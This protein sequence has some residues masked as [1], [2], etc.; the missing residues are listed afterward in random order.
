MTV[1][2]P[3]IK[4]MKVYVD[5]RIVGGDEAVI[6]VFD[7][8][9]LY[10][11]GVFEGIRVYGGRIFRCDAHIKRLYE[12]AASI[13]L[14]IPLSPAEMVEAMCA[15]VRATSLQDAYVRL[16]VTRGVGDLGLD[17]HKCPKPSVIVIVGKIALYPEEFYRQGLALVTAS[18][19][20]CA[21]DA[22]SPAIKSLN[23]LN[24]ILA[25]IQITDA[26]CLE[27]IMLNSQGHVAECTGDNLFIVKDGALA[28]PPTWAGILVGIT[29]AA[30]MELAAK[31]GVAICEKVLVLPDLYAADECFL[32]GTAAE[33]VPVVKIDGRLI[34]TGEPGP[35]TE[36]LR[37]A[38]VE[39]TKTDGHV[40]Y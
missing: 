25:K 16:V 11:D 5:G 29:R 23:Y 19:R 10:G 21:P 15:T 30:V 4:D 27:G 35:V 9:L 7:H 20:R 28:T 18:T 24:N 37:A 40:V 8:G 6:S 36:K 38:F 39:L 17:P 22:L 12:S 31:R 1:S 26:G 32:T 3:S 34:G 14:E 33:I 13:R 2:A